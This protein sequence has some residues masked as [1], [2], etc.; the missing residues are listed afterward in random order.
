[1]SPVGAEL[2]EVRS[3]YT[4]GVIGRVPMTP[5]DG[6]AQAVEAARAAVPGWR[7]MPLR[8]RTVLMS[9]FRSLLESN[10]D[11]LANLA[12][13]EAG[14]TVAEARAGLLKRSGEWYEGRPVMVT[15]NQPALGVFNGDIGLVLRAPGARGAPRVMRSMIV[16]AYSYVCPS[17]GAPEYSP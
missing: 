13:S 10:L 14:K 12:A 5:A 4:G 15:R 16:L 1:M 7:A 9:R 2:L 8:E 3:P 11:R 6:V 17:D